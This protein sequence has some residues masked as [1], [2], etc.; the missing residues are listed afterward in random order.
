LKFDFCDFFQVT[1]KVRDKSTT[2]QDA[3]MCWKL[4]AVFGLTWMLC[5]AAEHHIALRIIYIVFNSL[6]GTE[7]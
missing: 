1:K 6:Q 3:R 2:G 5:L 7:E 4:T